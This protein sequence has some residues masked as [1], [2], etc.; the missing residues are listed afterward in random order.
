MVDPRPAE[1]LDTLVDEDVRKR[2]TEVW[3][4]SGK[5]PGARYDRD[6]LP[7]RLNIWASSTAT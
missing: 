5:Q 4:I 6:W 3:L 2:A 7:R 1:H